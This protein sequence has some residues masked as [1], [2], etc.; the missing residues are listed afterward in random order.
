MSRLSFFSDL[1][2][3]WHLYIVSDGAGP[4]KASERGS[5]WNCIIGEYL[6]KGMVERTGWKKNS[7]LPSEIEWYQEFYAICR[8][9]K[10]V[11]EERVATLDEPIQPKD[12]NATLHYL[13]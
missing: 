4:A 12:C 2:E 1:G 10:S 13:F 6:L 11:I 7:E 5:R 9:I 8:K 3:D